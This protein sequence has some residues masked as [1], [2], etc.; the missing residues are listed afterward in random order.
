MFGPGSPGYALLLSPGGGGA[1]L[2]ILVNKH[3]IRRKEANRMAAEFVDTVQQVVYPG[4]CDVM[5]H[6]NTRHYTALFDHA[7]W[8]LMRILGSEDTYGSDA[9]MGW[10]D[11]ETIVRYR[12]EVNVGAAVRIRSRIVRVGNTSLVTEHVLEIQRLRPEPRELQW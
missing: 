10:V 5:G 6:L 2:D 1:D 12:R 3:P 4:D 9:T 11:V 8:V 7:M